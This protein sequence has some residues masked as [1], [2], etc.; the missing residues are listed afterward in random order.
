M[1]LVSQEKLSLPIVWTFALVFVVSV[2]HFF[3]SNILFSF[4]QIL[5]VGL[6]ILAQYKFKLLNFWVI[7]LCS[8]VYVI[9]TVM[10]VLSVL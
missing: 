7:N 2:F 1:N 9:L 4:L 5:L 3:D 8:F 10:W 6:V